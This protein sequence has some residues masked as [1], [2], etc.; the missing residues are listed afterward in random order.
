MWMK[1]SKQIKGD[2]LKQIMSWTRVYPNNEAPQCIQPIVFT[3]SFSA[4]KN[5]P[6]TYI[7][8]SVLDDRLKDKIMKR[9]PLF[10][11]SYVES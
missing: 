10:S 2:Y 4:Y 3:D 6:L 7:L 1:K 8:G 11:L 9:C 5:K